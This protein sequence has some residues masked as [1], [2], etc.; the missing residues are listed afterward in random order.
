M[1][2]TD[3]NRPQVGLLAEMDTRE[4]PVPTAMS[5][6]MP[7]PRGRPRSFDEREAL[8]KAIRVFSAKGY[9]AATIDDL[10][11]GMGVAR[12]SLYAVFGDKAA[13]FTRS[14][15][16]DAEGLSGDAKKALLGPPSVRDGVPS[17][18]MP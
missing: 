14:L 4:T 17:L 16:A 3:D 6:E 8:Q 18:L 12:P 15:R 1:S 5:P 2:S 10:A 9:D 7:R 11:A 13:L